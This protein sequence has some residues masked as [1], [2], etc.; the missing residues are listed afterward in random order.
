MRIMLLAPHPFYQ[1][2]GTP[3]AVDLL[4]KALENRGECVD[5]LAYHEGED[6]AYSR[7]ITIHRIPPQ[8]FANNIRPGF[9]IKKLIC[10]VAMY[11]KAA[12]LAR[13][14][15]YDCIHAVE[16]SAFMAR[17]IARKHSIPYIFDMDSSMPQQIADKLP[18]AKH[19]LPIMRKF[20]AMIV[21]SATAVV[22]MC[23]ALADT[24][25]TD[26]FIIDH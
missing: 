9:S 19:F 12:A 2:R 7:N 8:R 14:N 16:E 11:K 26:P 3:I 21:R 6:I 17:R 25:T 13:S 18:I 5:I 10:D 23:Q 15:N 22:P 20:E 1:E 24:G 4:A